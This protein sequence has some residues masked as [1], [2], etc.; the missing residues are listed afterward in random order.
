[1][2][3]PFSVK[4][5]VCIIV[6]LGFALTWKWCSPPNNRSGIYRAKERGNYRLPLAQPPL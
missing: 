4:F 6:A 2:A 1:L 5:Y 3:N